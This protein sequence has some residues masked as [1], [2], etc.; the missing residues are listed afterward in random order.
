MSTMAG[1]ACYPN[2]DTLWFPWFGTARKAGWQIHGMGSLFSHWDKYPR[3]GWPWSYLPCYLDK[4]YHPRFVMGIGNPVWSCKMHNV[5]PIP[6]APFS[7]LNWLANC[8]HHKQIFLKPLFLS[9]L[10]LTFYSARH[11]HGRLVGVGFVVLVIMRH[12]TVTILRSNAT[13]RR[14]TS[15]HWGQGFMACSYWTCPHIHPIL[16]R[17]KVKI[18]PFFSRP[19]PG[20][21]T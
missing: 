7:V 1:N 3:N 9:R 2:N 17:Q 13:Y 14:E 21:S 4:L 10:G 5:Q 11:V 6:W 18:D 20:F 16:L 15:H 8:S 12:A 19:S